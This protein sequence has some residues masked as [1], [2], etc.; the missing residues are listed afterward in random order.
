MANISIPVETH[1]VIVLGYIVKREKILLLQRN[2]RPYV[3]AIPGGS[4]KIDE[5]PKDGL[6]REL[7][8]ETN[9]EVDIVMP[10]DYWFG[11]HKGRVVLGLNFLC[12]NPRGTLTLNYEHSDFRWSTINDIRTFYNKN[13]LFQEPKKYE[14]VLRLAQKANS[15]N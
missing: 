13:L 9:F 7:I 10:F 2:Q 12:L 11:R 3:W 1:H 14:R 5:D 4:L 6:R 15:I 8:E